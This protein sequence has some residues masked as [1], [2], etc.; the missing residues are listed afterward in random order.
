MF[1]QCGVIQ[2]HVV[3]FQDW[4]VLSQRLALLQTWDEDLL[5][6]KCTNAQW[7][8]TSAFFSIQTTRLPYMLARIKTLEKESHAL[9]ERQQI[10]M[11]GL[12][13]IIL[14]SI[15]EFGGS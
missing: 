4:H 5:Q 1:L 9:Q 3:W 11:L 10:L 6:R 15:D 8:P 14:S 12:V 13:E 2:E 7:Q